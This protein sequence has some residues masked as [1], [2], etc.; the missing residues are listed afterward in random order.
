MEQSHLLPDVRANANANGNGN[1]D[2]DVDGNPYFQMADLES[3]REEQEQEQQEQPRTAS[4]STGG[5]EQESEADFRSEVY[6]LDHFLTRCYTYYAEHGFAAIVTQSIAQLLTSLFSIGFF[7][8]LALFIDWGALISCGRGASA[9][10]CQ[11]I[12]SWPPELTH[13]IKFVL[14]SGALFTVYWLWTLYAL[15]RSMIGARRIQR[16]YGQK[17]GIDDQ[18]LQMLTWSQVVDR[19]VSKQQQGVLGVIHKPL[20]HLTIAN[21]IM[22][23]DN[24][25]V[26]LINDDVLNLKGGREWLFSSA[27]CGN[28]QYSLFSLLFLGGEGQVNQHLLNTPF[29]LQRKFCTLGLINLVLTPF[30]LV[31]TLMMFFFKNTEEFY[32]G[33]TVLGPRRWNVYA[34]WRLRQLNELPHFVQRRLDIAGKQA[35]LFL[36]EYPNHVLSH[37]C[38]MGAFIAGAFV[39]V[40]LVF[41]ITDSSLLVSIRVA[42][43]SLLW[44]LAF[45]S[46]IVAVCRS[47]I[48]SAPVPNKIPPTTSFDKQLPRTE[49][50]YR[51]VC[52]YTHMNH[53][54]VGV[55]PDDDDDNNEIKRQVRNVTPG[56]LGKDSS[57][58]AN[59]NANANATTN[60][61]G[62]TLSRY[63][64][65]AF[66]RHAALRQELGG[67]YPYKLLDL[68]VEVLGVILSPWM[69]LCYM[70]QRAPAIIDFLRA[71]GLNT[72]E[73]GH[74]CAMAAFQPRQRQPQPPALSSEQ[75]D[76]ERHN[77][78]RQSVVQFDVDQPTWRHVGAAAEPPTDASSLS[79]AEDDNGP[80]GTDEGQLNM[81]SSLADA[82]ADTRN[83]NE[84]DDTDSVLLKSMADLVTDRPFGSRTAS[85]YL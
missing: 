58:R 21:R 68:G 41:T 74:V 54:T 36:D 5:K 3:G 24:F 61:D 83:H 47:C 59:A 66:K 67:L 13:T 22:R 75:E 33:R 18:Q 69:L 82:D 4:P 77:K 49:M 55:K 44:Y 25:M 30:F 65:D 79:L 50:L 20:S 10:V 35:Q 29:V 51:R 9:D 72:D 12:F 63:A 8:F 53:D 7:L 32:N 15:I 31:Y 57:I 70:P 60:V 40:L 11:T 85:L 37:L 17:L 78:M 6:Y 2:V 26:A 81:L 52:S 80:T 45:F 1:V 28:L 64:E 16:F 73:M 38:R 14:L 27:L 43:C 42:G 76:N 62:M 56:H 23:S 19:I 46:S 48:A 84:R 34:Q 71:N 39:A